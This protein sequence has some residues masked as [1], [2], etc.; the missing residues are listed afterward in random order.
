MWVYCGCVAVGAVVVGAVGG[1]EGIV[2]GSVVV[3]CGVWFKMRGDESE[4]Q[5]RPTNYM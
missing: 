5:F 4:E 3:V 2:G 1:R